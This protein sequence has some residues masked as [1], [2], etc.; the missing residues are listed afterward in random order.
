MGFFTGKVSGVTRLKIEGGNAVS[1]LPIFDEQIKKRAFRSLFPENSE[2][3]AGFVS[4]NDC[5]DADLTTEKTLLGNYRVFS[6]RIDR[7]VVSPSSM[8]IRMLEEEKK[9]LKD[10]GRQR[11][12]KS[13]RNMIKDAVRI[14]L[15]KNTPPVTAIYDAAIDMNL[16]IVYI[17]PLT[18]NLIQTFMDIFK[19]TFGV[20]LQLINP[21]REELENR[22]V[23][24]PELDISREFMTWLWYRSN[25]DECRFT[26]NDDIYAVN[27]VRRMVF[28]SMGC[29]ST[30]TV[31]VCSEAMFDSEEA[32]EA[33]HQGKKVKEARINIEKDDEATAWEFGYKG[34]SF[35]FQSVALP[36]SSALEENETPDG[37]NLER[38]YMMT[39]MID[40]MDGLFKM[41]IDLRVSQK[42]ESELSAMLAWARGDEEE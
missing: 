7:R 3:S 21:V 4:I 42:W 10:T 20:S 32:K 18:T 26:M 39:S 35:Q 5:L 25:Q 14:E 24:L 16:G 34:D 40:V 23:T 19:A 41:F 2:I 8:K 33:F 11:L 1:S 38:L 37:R 15:L 27:F 6:L 12:S 17:S 9:R 13:E 30:E 28:E 22:K 31:V 36:V 29:E